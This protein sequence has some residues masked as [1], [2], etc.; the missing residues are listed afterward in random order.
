[1]HTLGYARLSTPCIAEIAE[2]GFGVYDEVYDNFPF[3]YFSNC[4][5]R[6]NSVIR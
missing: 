2:N 6:S 5:F 3:G 4:K 1:M